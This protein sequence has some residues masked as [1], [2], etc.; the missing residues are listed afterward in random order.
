MN[1]NIML[2]LQDLN[3][4]D[5][6]GSK[7]YTDKNCITTTEIPISSNMIIGN[8]PPGTLNSPLRLS[9]YLP[10]QAIHIGKITIKIPTRAPA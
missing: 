3:Q 8:L 1:I 2:Y 9:L 5:G 4:T 10:L 6:L 7:L